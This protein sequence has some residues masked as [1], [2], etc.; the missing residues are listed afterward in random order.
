MYV[1]LSVCIFNLPAIG[2]VAYY[3]WPA[4]GLVIAAILVYGEKILFGVFIGAFIVNIRFS[5]FMDSRDILDIV[6]NSTII[7]FGA[8]LSPYIVSVI[9]KIFGLR[10]DKLQDYKEIFG[11]LVVGGLLGSIITSTVGSLSLFYNKA[12]GFEIFIDNWIAWWIGDTLG[13]FLF[14]PIFFQIFQHKHFK[15]RRIFLTSVPILAGVILSCISHSR[16]SSSKLRLNESILEDKGIRIYNRI[17]ADI[18]NKKTVLESF[19]AFYESSD[20]ITRDDFFSY[21]NIFLNKFPDINGIMWAPRY[22]SND[23]KKI[24]KKFLEI[25]SKTLNDINQQ[26]LPAMKSKKSVFPVLYA[27]PFYKMVNHVGYDITEEFSNENLEITYNSRNEILTSF[28]NEEDEDLRQSLTLKVLVPVFF[29]ETKEL[30]GY[31]VADINFSKS[32]ENILE[33]LK[34][35][36]TNIQMHESKI[37]NGKERSLVYSTFR[38]GLVPSELFSSKHSLRLG[39]TILDFQIFESEFEKQQK[40]SF[41][42]NIFIVISLLFTSIFGIILLLI[43]GQKE[44][45]ADVVAMKTIDLKRSKIDVERSAEKL[46]ELA[47]FKGQFLQVISSDIKK[48]LIEVDNSIRNLEIRKNDNELRFN[49]AKIK[50]DQQVLNHIIDDVLY[51]S[52]VD[53]IDFSLK[54]NNFN[55]HDLLQRIAE[56]YSEQAKEKGLKFDL[57]ISGDCPEFIYSDRERLG[58]V[59]ENLLENA[60]AYTHVGRVEIFVTSSSLQNH[61]SFINVVVRDTGI[62]IAEDD[63]MHLFTLSSTIKLKM[64]KEIKSSGL[65]L[66]T[67]SKILKHLGADLNVASI[68][69]KG[70]EFS[71]S[72]TCKIVS[73]LSSKDFAENDYSLFSNLNVLFC[74]DNQINQKVIAAIAK[75]LQLRYDFAVNGVSAIQLTKINKYD[76]IFMDINMPELN[77]LDATNEI[78]SHSLNANTPVVALT[79]NLFAE[80]RQKSIEIGMCD[81][82][83]KPIR[84]VDIIRVLKNIIDKKYN[85]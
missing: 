36:S 43:V 60:I 48:V 46:K 21:S 41:S 44:T 55:L 56:K 2:G 13:V 53:S 7:S 27:E 11:V 37:G 6:L 33:K 76:V 8:I 47:S 45:I 28:K 35:R 65:G 24:N 71:F 20:D 80:T 30:Q 78:K 39:S 31:I 70:S 15:K 85:S 25:Y 83:E 63:L 68:I 64:N 34:F 79:L 3:L 49:I 51:Y 59:I 40:N 54:F 38:K 9:F 84:S 18:E 69:N 29:T 50:G 23:F 1:L 4:A 67:S 16:L 58:V 17:V 81:F 12:I 72:F 10:V 5:S 62:G 77:G 75:K 52:E 32:I 57:T 61:M 82:I 26:L 42:E 14:F 19:K 73:S 66:V 74:E 22:K